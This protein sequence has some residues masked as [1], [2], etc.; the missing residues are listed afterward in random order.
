MKVCPTYVGVSTICFYNSY[1]DAAQ[2]GVIRAI[3]A[4]C[5][6]P[7]LFFNV[8]KKFPQGAL[9]AILGGLR[10]LYVP[11]EMREA[12]PKRA[13]KV[14]KM[15]IFA[16]DES[17]T[18]N[19]DLIQALEMGRIVSRDIGGSDPERMAAPR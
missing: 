5:R 9:V 14:E 12:N 2:R 10:A 19:M 11:L 1:A 18:K 16:S 17:V 4:G 7:C 3:K 8:K 15:G 13:Q 6:A